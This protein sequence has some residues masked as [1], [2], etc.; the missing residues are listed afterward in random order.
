MDVGFID[1][2]QQTTL[3]Q[4]IRQQPL[5]AF[6]KISSLAR[7]PFIQQLMGFFPGKP[8]L[9]EDF[10]NRVTAAVDAKLQLHPDD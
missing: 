3:M 9:F 4:G 7:V 10:A 8:Q 6:E 2:N 1:I 5:E